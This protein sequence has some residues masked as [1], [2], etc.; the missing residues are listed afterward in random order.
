MSLYSRRI[1]K[2]A[3]V[4]DDGGFE[5][6]FDPVE[7]GASELLPLGNNDKCI[8][9]VERG[10]QCARVRQFRL[11]AGIRRISFIAAGS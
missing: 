1:V 3:A 10:K 4:E 9:I 7:I 8:G 5:H 11:F 2:I 6:V